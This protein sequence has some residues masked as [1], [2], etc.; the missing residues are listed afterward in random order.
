MT[1]ELISENMST[2]NFI[3][4]ISILLVVARVSNSASVQTFLQSVETGTLFH[5]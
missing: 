4:I 2:S 1:L 5:I 3:K